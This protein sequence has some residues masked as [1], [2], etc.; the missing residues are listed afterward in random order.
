MFGIPGISIIGSM[1]VP[2]GPLS[3]HGSGGWN[4]SDWQ[5]TVQRARENLAAH[6]RASA[7]KHNCALV[8]ARRMEADAGRPY[9][10]AAVS[11]SRDTR[12]MSYTEAKLRLDAALSRTAAREAEENTPGRRLQ[13]C[14]AWLRRVGLPVG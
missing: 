9:A 2:H 13:D 8:E 10:P 14:R 7:L 5:R 6:K 4:P 12:R 3:N 11:Q 1:L